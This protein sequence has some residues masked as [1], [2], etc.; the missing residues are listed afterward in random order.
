MDNTKHTAT[1]I[2]NIKEVM[3]HSGNS[4]WVKS[5][6]GFNIQVGEEK[7]LEQWKLIVR[8]CN[9]HDALVEALK[10]VRIYLEN[11]DTVDSYIIDKIN[12]T[13]KQ[14]ETI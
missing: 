4:Y 6:N 14:A 13:L 11:L 2:L 10:E 9:S 12:K 5:E 7:E 3:R 8:A 1:P